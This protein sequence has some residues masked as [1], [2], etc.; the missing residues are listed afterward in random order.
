MNEWIS[1]EDGL[2]ELEH[3]IEDRMP[4]WAAPYVR[5]KGHCGK[6]TGYYVPGDRMWFTAEEH[7]W[8]SVTHW[9]PLSD[10]PK[11]TT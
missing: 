8:I 9:M 5:V 4:T 6:T 2:P 11:D 10:S 7:K 3:Y 1:V